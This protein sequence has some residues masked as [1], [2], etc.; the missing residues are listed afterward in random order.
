MVSI[1]AVKLYKLHTNAECESLSVSSETHAWLRIVLLSIMGKR[2][3]FSIKLKLLNGLHNYTFRA[4]NLILKACN[5]PNY[6]LFTLY[7]Y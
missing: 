5:K 6:S 4:F 1:I 2:N 7:A 3:A